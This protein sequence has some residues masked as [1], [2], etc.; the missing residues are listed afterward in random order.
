MITLFPWSSWACT[1]R[2]VKTPAAVISDTQPTVTKIILDRSFIGFFL[3]H[4][5]V[6]EERDK[7][8]VFENTSFV[9]LGTMDGCYCWF[10]ELWLR[11]V[12]VTEKPVAGLPST[13]SDVTMLSILFPPSLTT[14]WRTPVV[15]RNGLPV[16]TKV[17]PL[18]DPSKY[19]VN[20]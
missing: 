19:S 3:F 1:A 17:A 7:L 2:G 10:W 11:S 9:T 6:G 18:H 16:G 4:G 5:L 20:A 8:G 12:K 14:K 13:L 15:T